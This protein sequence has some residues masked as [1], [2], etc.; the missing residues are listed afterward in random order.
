MPRLC[1]LLAFAV[2]RVFGDPLPQPFWP[3]E[4]YVSETPA[5]NVGFSN[6][7]MFLLHHARVTH[8]WEPTKT[9]PI[10]FYCGHELPLEDYINN[11]TVPYLNYFTALQA[12]ADYAHL[13]L[14]I[15]ETVHRADK[16]PV[17]AF[18]GF[19]GGM[20]AAYFRLKY[21][22]LVAGDGVADMFFTRN[23]DMKQ[24]RHTCKKRF[25][26]KPDPQKIY[27]MFGN[28]LETSSNIILS[29]GEL[30]PWSAV[31]YQA[32]KTKSV[33]PILIRGAA[34]Q[35]DFRFPSLTDSAALIRA[36]WE[37]KKYVR[38]WIEEAGSD[39]GITV[40]FDHGDGKTRDA[41]ARDRKVPN[42]VGPG[43]ETPDVRAPDTETKD[44]ETQNTSEEYLRHEL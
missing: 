37:E 21:P 27:S 20:L 44:E 28:R 5:D 40:L 6:N 2:A 39:E 35:E 3:V 19:Y 7:D 14:H 4:Y 9:G 36:R 23:W 32:P 12:L 1:L 34:H 13:I 22:H 31:G 42:F 43:T 24:M 17:I 16:V 25:R 30:D 26:V 10:F 38:K 8:F 29:N 18:G 41:E 33:I 11:T 15:K